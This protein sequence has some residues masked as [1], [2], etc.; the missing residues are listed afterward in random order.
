MKFQLLAVLFILGCQITCAQTQSHTVFPQG[1]I[2]EATNK[3]FETKS[4]DGSFTASGLL[5]AQSGIRNDA[6]ATSM[7]QMLAKMQEFK[8]GAPQI[9]ARGSHNLK[10]LNDTVYVYND[11][12]VITG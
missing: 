6:R 12:L 4:N 7:I 3:G 2:N 11:T 1:Q 5:H 8:R 10:S 9:T